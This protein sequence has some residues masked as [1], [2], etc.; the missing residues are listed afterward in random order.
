MNLIV[1]KRFFLLVVLS[2]II[3]PNCGLFAQVDSS[4]IYN[5][6]KGV[7]DL[8]EKDQEQT[9]KDGD[10]IESNF[11][12][13]EYSKKKHA[14]VGYYGTIF[15][16]GIGNKKAL[17]HMH[18]DLGVFY[19]GRFIKTAKYKMN[20]EFWAEQNSLLIG[21]S[22]GDLA[23][24]M[25]MFSLV[26]GSSASGHEI[27]LEYLYVENIFFNGAWDVTFGKIDPLFLVTMTSYSSWDKMTFFSYTAASDPVP[28]LIA[29]F[30][31]F[32]EINL[33]NYFG[34]GGLILDNN[35]KSDFID[36]SGFFNNATYFYQ[37]FVNW[38]IPSKQDYTSEH[39][40][41]YY[42]TE[43]TKEEGRGNGI[44]YVGNQGI[45]EKVVFTLKAYKGWGTTDEYDGAFSPGIVLLNPSKLKG[46]QFGAAFLIN[47]KKGKYE[48]GIDSYMKF[49]LAPWIS[50]SANI[51]LYRFN[52]K[53][54]FFP[55]LRVMITY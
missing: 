28:P 15:Q 53:F 34:F 38:A 9:Q 6:K 20:V 14:A 7:F 54:G 42:Y 23:K 47:E 2:L 18:H 12:K 8:I 32:T 22:T 19:K 40:V 39:V 46:D 35:S 17:P 10:F 41:S 36:V 49:K 44:I 16:Y 25:G 55:G 50:T 51:Q 37:G 27:G 48:Y 29:G 5:E 26:N 11:N 52:K 24:E 43:A 31:F 21:K 45:S 3:M 1:Y 4:K 13:W 33:S 30:G